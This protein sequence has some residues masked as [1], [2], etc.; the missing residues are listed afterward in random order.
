MATQ[1]AV[2]GQRIG[3]HMKMFL[4]INR[5]LGR[6]VTKEER[7]KVGMHLDILGIK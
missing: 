3:P 2:S 1:H 4:R 7:E 6:A 5:R